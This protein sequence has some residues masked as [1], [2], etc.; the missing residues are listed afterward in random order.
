MGSE[1]KPADLES[2]WSFYNTAQQWPSEM[3]NMLEQSTDYFYNNKYDEISTSQE[4]ISALNDTA[5]MIRLKSQEFVDEFVGTSFD[6]YTEDEEEEN[7]LF[8]ES[9]G[10]EGHIMGDEKDWTPEMA[11]FVRK[12]REHREQRGFNFHANKYIK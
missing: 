12:T 1:W 6:E 7:D 2:F 10:V 9:F 8:D 4:H 11:E 5:S 3:K